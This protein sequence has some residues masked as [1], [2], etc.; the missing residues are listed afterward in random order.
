MLKTVRTFS[1][2]A[3]SSA[4]L[5]GC[6][7]SNTSSGGMPTNS[8]GLN[9]IAGSEIQTIKPLLDQAAK[10][11]G[12][13]I[14][15]KYSGTI[16]GVESVK[17]GGDYDVA[18]FGNSKYFYDTPESAKRIKQS[19]KIMLSPVI[20]GVKPESFKKNNLS[21]KAN[22]T[23]KDISSW[24]QTKNMTY[25][26]TDPS[27]SNSGYV[28]LMGVVYATANKGENITVADV[29]K[30]VLQSFF[31]GQKVTAKSSNWIME[32]FNKEPID[33]VVNYEAAILSN[34]SKLVPVYPQEGIVTS[35]YSML[36][37]NTDSAKAEKYKALVDYLK[38]KES[39]EALVEQYH[40]R[41][42]N[43][44]VMGKQKVFDQN[45]LLVEM[46]F[47][48]DNQVSEE[49]ITAYFNEY[50]KPAKFAFV[51]DTSGSMG[52]SREREMKQLIDGFV[53]GNISKYAT[54]RNRESILIVPFSDSVHDV[55]SFDSAAKNEMN[56]FIQNLNMDGGTAMYDA[57]ASAMNA[58][59]QDKKVNGEKYRYSVVVLTDGMSN[60]GAD[61]GEF[62]NWFGRNNIGSQDMRVFAISFGDAD[63]NQL[64]SLTGI[65]GGKVFDGKSSL[66]SAFRE[67]RSYQ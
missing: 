15:F 51:I 25:A 17:S 39:Q 41:S 48:P 1:V 31:K 54:V 43:N 40:Y 16:E 46:P 66:S 36:L 21:E 27:V 42:I 8:N 65:T 34:P 50:K 52:G 26:M 6:G 22:Y 67:I 20:I 32:T 47:N 11:L 59:I 33:F 3:L 13:S 23:W 18:W 38:K 57:V 4:I 44:E 30:N 5:F 35:D 12:F 14:N 53:K 29:N 55:K 49:I 64:N 45:K 2:I 24:V 62:K 7:Q 60:Q 63:L 58:L 56:S 19:E 9:I 61:F 37:I 10:D 28:A